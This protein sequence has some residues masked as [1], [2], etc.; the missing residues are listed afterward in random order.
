MFECHELM[1][2]AGWKYETTILWLRV[3]S[4]TENLRVVPASF[5]AVVNT[6]AEV[7]LV[8]YRQQT[9]RSGQPYRQ[10]VG[11]ADFL[12]WTLGC[13]PSRPLPHSNMDIAR[14]V[15]MDEEAVGLWRRR[16]AR[17]CS[18]PLAEL[19]A[20]DR[21]ADAARPGA[22]PRLTAEQVC[23]IVALACEQPTNS[24]RPISQWSHR[25]LAGEI[26]RRGI[27]ERISPRH[28]ARLLKS[29]R[30]PAAPSALLAHPGRRRRSRHQDR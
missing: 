30:P 26:V 8:Y 12:D 2:L 21:L 1:V 5:G 17:W 27:T 15:P 18:V 9:K 13:G 29:G 28:A 16:W 6:A 25:E 10:T 11:A 24:G 14:Q 4:H 19:S 20:A 22:V 23:Q 3:M 7:V